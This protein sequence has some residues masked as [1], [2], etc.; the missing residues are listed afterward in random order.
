VEALEQT[1][2]EPAA[3]DARGARRRQVHAQEPLALRAREGPLWHGT[4]GL[5]AGAE[6]DD[7]PLVVP[8][9]PVTHGEHRVGVVA[10]SAVVVRF[11]DERVA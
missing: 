5:L 3:R 8:P 7:G 2:V 10:G 1:S 9:D 4:G 11:L 6:V